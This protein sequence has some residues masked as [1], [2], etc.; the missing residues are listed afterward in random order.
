MKNFEEEY[1]NR[2]GEDCDNK[3]TESSNIENIGSNNV[4]IQILNQEKE[5]TQFNIYKLEIE[6]RIIND[7]MTKSELIENIV[8]QHPNITKKHIEFIINS[9]FN[10]IKD[11]LQKGEKVEIRGFGSFKIRE[12][13]SKVGRNPKTGEE[14]VIEPRTVVVFRPSQIFKDDVND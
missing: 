3:V 6:Q 5:K 10:S 2:I 9:V 14:T 8:A 11:S 1:L 7:M 4:Y 12:K 13:T